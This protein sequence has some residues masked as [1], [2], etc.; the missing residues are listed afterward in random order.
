MT[1]QESI[2]TIQYCFLDL[3]SNVL[4]KTL[5]KKAEESEHLP[6]DVICQGVKLEDFPKTNYR[7]RRQKEKVKNGYKIIKLR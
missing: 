4:K 5:L 6:L 2:M 1:V 7:R 3:L